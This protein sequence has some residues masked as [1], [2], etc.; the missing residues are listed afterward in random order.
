MNIIDRVIGAEIETQQ[1]ETFGYFEHE[2]NSV[3]ELVRQSGMLNAPGYNY[4][5][6][7]Q[8]SDGADMKRWKRPQLSLCTLMFAMIAVAAQA[9]ATT[10]Q[11]ACKM[12]D[13]DKTWLDRTV[14]AWRHAAINYGQFTV[15]ANARVVIGNA[16]CVLISDTALFPAIPVAWTAVNGKGQ[17]PVVEDVVMPL[18]PVSQAIEVGGKP[19]F[20]MSTP[21]VWRTFDIPGGKIGLENLMTAVFIHET[22]HVLQQK[23]YFAQLDAIAKSHGLPEDFDDDSIQRRFKADDAFAGSM[24][25]E[26]ALLFA[27]AKEPT[28]ARARQ[29]AQQMLSLAKARRSRYFVGND[30]YLADVEDIFLTLE[31][32]GQWLGH[33]WLIDPTGGNVPE[34]DALARFT[35]DPGFWSQEQGLAL[36]LVVDRLDRGAWKKIAFGDGGRSGI[37]FLEA[38]LAGDSGRR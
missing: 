10:D 31:G 34:A 37:A 2:I 24:R 21:S 28:V 18:S 9:L 23:S 19:Y 11:P 1:R 29:R 32:S 6:H 16:D 30:A 4:P 15:P 8:A 12:Q 26:T 14:F 35:T 38:A 22:A 25:R 5:T 20:V 13:S 33:Q 36:F 7:L 27:A 17:I 3:N